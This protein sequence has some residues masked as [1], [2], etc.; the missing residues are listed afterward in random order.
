[1]PLTGISLISDKLKSIVISSTRS[2]MLILF[3]SDLPIVYSKF[4]SFSSDVLDTEFEINCKYLKVKKC[5]KMQ[6]VN[7]YPLPAVDN[8]RDI[9]IVSRWLNFSFISSRITPR[10]RS[11]AINWIIF[12]AAKSFLKNLLVF[13]F[14][15]IRFGIRMKSIEWSGWKLLPI[16]IVRVE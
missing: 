7:I 3:L 10:L 15:L 13:S 12:E 11:S 1:M 16:P 14:D 8:S 2:L 9:N 5:I 4:V 6:N